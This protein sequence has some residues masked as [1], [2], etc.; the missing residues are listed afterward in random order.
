MRLA[1]SILA[2]TLALAAP[3]AHADGLP[4]V[5]HAFLIVLENK[6][7]DQSFGPNSGAP[8]LARTLTREGQLLRQYYGTSHVSLG[9]YITMISGQAPNP[10][11]RGDCMVA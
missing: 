10:D 7:F 6:D 4:P 3:A 11:T 8:Y 5:R 9:N 2:L 1:L